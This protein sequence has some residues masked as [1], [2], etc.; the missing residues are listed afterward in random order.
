[1]GRFFQKTEAT[2]DLRTPEARP[3]W[4][5][6]T[7]CPACGRRGYLDHVDPAAGVMRQHC[8]DCWHEWETFESETA[9][10]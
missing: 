6:P 1:M 5:K 10:V 3:V 2:I 8:P 9:A 7:R 4:G